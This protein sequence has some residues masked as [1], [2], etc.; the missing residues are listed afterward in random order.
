MNYYIE[1]FNIF[2]LNITFDQDTLVTVAR[3]SHLGKMIQHRIIK[4]DVVI[5]IFGKA[6]GS[7]FSLKGTFT[8]NIPPMKLLWVVT[9]TKVP[10]VTNFL[11][12]P[13]TQSMAL[14]YP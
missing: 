7:L 3:Y 4:T 14:V 5:H 10:I 11:I 2:L 8:P 6:L 9:L 1:L 13:N 12:L